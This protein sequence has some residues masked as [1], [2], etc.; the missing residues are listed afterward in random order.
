MKR[1]LRGLV[2][3]WG[4]LGAEGA[5]A[6]RANFSW[7]VP[8]TVSVVDIPGSV[9][10]NGVPVKLRAVRSKE[11]LEVILQ[12]VVNR[13]EDW[14]FL[15]PPGHKQPQLMREPMITAI[16]TRQL[17][18]YTAILQPNPDGT[19]TVIVGEAYFSQFRRPGAS[20]LPVMPGGSKEVTAETEGTRTTTYTVTGKTVAEV[21]AFY[22]EEL[23]R[24]GFKEV[25]PRLFRSSGEELQLHVGVTKEGPV[26]VRLIRRAALPDDGLSPGE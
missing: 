23:G 16:D 12:H 1:V 20:G 14:G 21:D 5:W 26:A 25:Q 18:S 7:D 4:L 10:A 15:V 17:I 24:R 19:T 11:K 3:V 8:K 13:F 9:D 2:L 22:R 6:Q